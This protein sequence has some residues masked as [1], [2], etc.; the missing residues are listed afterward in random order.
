M[1]YGLLGACENNHLHVVKHILND[2]DLNFH[3]NSPLYYSIESDERG[4]IPNRCLSVLV[5]N[6]S[7]ESLHYILYELEDRK[8]YPFR[9]E[10]SKYETF[11]VVKKLTEYKEL[12]VDLKR[13]SIS[14]KATKK[15]KV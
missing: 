3:T 1:L 11:P 12:Q 8:S 9:L 7:I 13:Q 4:N 5:H 6:N 14:H 10:V 15:L 2:K